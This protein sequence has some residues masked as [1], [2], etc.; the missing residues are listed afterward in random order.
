MSGPYFGSHKCQEDKCLDHISVRTNAR[1]TNAWTHFWF[2]QM[3][4]GQMPGPYFGSDKCLNP[5]FLR[6]IAK[7]TNVLTHIWFG[8]MSGGQMPGARSMHLSFEAFVRPGICPL[9]HLFRLDKCQDQAFVL[10]GTCSL[11]HLSA[12][13]NKS[14]FPLHSTKLAKQLRQIAIILI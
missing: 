2:G 10:P 6:T 11:R 9:T 1:R 12:N 5:H 8:Q 13:R 14:L 7:G 3:P 4:G